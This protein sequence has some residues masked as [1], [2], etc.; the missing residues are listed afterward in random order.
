[1]SG[2]A[3]ENLTTS[4]QILELSQLGRH[5]TNNRPSYIL[6]GSTLKSTELASIILAV[7]V[8]AGGLATALCVVCVRYKR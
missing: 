6:N 8:F 5:N 3:I 7:I 4:A 2:I 1:M